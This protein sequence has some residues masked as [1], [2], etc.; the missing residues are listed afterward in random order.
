MYLHA[1][2]ILHQK[3][4]RNNINTLT[5]FHSSV[6][7]SLSIP[8][9]KWVLAKITVIILK[10]KPPSCKTLKGKWLLPIGFLFT[11]VF[12]SIFWT[13]RFG[14]C[15][16][17]KHLEWVSWLLRGERW[18]CPAPVCNRSDACC[19][20]IQEPPWFGHTYVHTY[21]RFFVLCSRFFQA[22][23]FFCIWWEV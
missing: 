7:N 8:G 21:S 16:G 3:C 17:L 4:F 20:W 5:Y 12:S 1:L 22:I 14:K 2:E 13:M 23:C 19:M 15:L 18:C 6:P 9:G 10:H 11:L